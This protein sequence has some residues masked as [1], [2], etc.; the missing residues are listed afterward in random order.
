MQP[1]LVQHSLDVAGESVQQLAQF[2]TL[3][4]LLLLLLCNGS[5]VAGL[6]RR[7]NGCTELRDGFG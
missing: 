1:R 6:Q 7:N 4:L 2:S 3:T 5:L